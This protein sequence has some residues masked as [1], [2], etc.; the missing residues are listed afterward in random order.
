MTGYPLIMRAFYPHFPHLPQSFQSPYFRGFLAKL[1]VPFL[2]KICYTSLALNEKK[3]W[4]REMGR[5]KIYQEDN[6][7]STVISNCFIDNYM[8]DANDAQLKVYLYLV[9]LMGANMS[10]SISDIADKF[11][12]TEKDVLRALRYW[13]KQALLSLDYDDAKM[14]SGIRLHKAASAPPSGPQTEVVS[15]APAVAFLPKTAAVPA[16]QPSFAKPGYSTE[17]LKNFRNNE[18]TSQ[19]LFI[20]E[21]YIGKPLSASEVRTVLFIY[22]VLGFSADLIDYLIQY[23]V[24][25]GQ[26]SF[27]YIE[28]VAINWAEAKI[29]TQKQA[30]AFSKKH[31]RQKCAAG[32]VSSGSSY[33]QFMHNTYDYDALERELLQK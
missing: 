6:A 25:K 21:Q 13:E 30:A 16:P 14:L 27:A 26:K 23:C 33:N 28:K 1:P 32:K 3:I 18:E 20:V 24:G 10:T 12:H 2:E 22:D 7:D 11:N 31:D 17:Q 9:R 5:L 8:K 19:L 15:I 29:T 4:V